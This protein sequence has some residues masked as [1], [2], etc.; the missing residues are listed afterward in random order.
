MKNKIEFH[1]HEYSPSHWSIDFTRAGT[2]VATF[3]VRNKYHF[4]VIL[5]PTDCQ[6]YR[7]IIR[8]LNED[9]SSLSSAFNRTYTLSEQRALNDVTA[10]MTKVYEK[11]GVIAQFSQL[12]NNSHHFDPNTRVVHVGD[13]EEPSLLHLHMWGRGDPEMEYIP[14][15]PLRGPKPGLMFDLRAKKEPNKE[16]LQKCLDTF[17]SL[18]DDYIKSP[19]FLDE[20]G[21]SVK[22][23]FDN[24]NVKSVQVKESVTSGPGFFSSTAD[25]KSSEPPSPS[26]QLPTLKV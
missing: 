6:G 9:S 12:G 21:N 5:N 11:L 17:K 8:Y 25:H 18:L 16:E 24:P 23:S 22:I 7:S 20:F 2:S 3:N 1:K 4:S 10:I 15:V 26:S 19:E 13:D 14:G